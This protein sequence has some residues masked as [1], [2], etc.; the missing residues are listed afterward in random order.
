MG[1]LNN[2]VVYSTIQGTAFGQQIIMDMVWQVSGDFPLGNTV[3]TD[4]GLI[5]TGLSAGGVQDVLTPYLA[6][7]PATY[8]ALEVRSQ[9]VYPLRMA[10]RSLALVGAVGT[11]VN[12]ATVANRSACITKRTDFSGRNQVANNHIG[13]APDASAA[14]GVITPAYTALLNALA[15]K[16]VT[17]WVP[18][19]SGSLLIPVI[20]HKNQLPVISTNIINAFNIGAT[21][22]VQR[23]RTIGVGA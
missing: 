7:L 22:R 6:C 5:N 1:L 16:L 23:R 17:A 18:P 2:D 11:N 19:T 21:A 12:P 4:L 15:S 8:S 3:F 10:Y 14:A 13:P 20:F 9:R